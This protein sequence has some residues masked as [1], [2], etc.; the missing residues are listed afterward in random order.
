MFECTVMRPLD[1][2]AVHKQSR[3]LL[4]TSFDDAQRARLKDV[5]MKLPR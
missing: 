3:D 5:A 2:D 4:F 1:N